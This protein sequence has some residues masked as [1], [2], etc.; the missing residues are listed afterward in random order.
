MYK[1]L[2][3]ILPVS[4]VVLERDFYEQLG[5]ERHLNPSEAYPESEFAA[6]DYGAHILFGVARSSD[7][8]SKTAECRLWWQIEASDLDAVHRRAADARL[9]IE[10][11]PQLES[12]GQRTLKI[13]SPNGYL[14]VFEGD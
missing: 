2:I 4:D 13:R 7:F 6:L 1:R 3:P 14:V 9:P 12:W 10:Q 5:F 8:D 11:A